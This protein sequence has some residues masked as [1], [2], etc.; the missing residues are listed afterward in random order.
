VRSRAAL[1]LLLRSSD[2][3]RST[4]GGQV[5]TSYRH[6]RETADARCAAGACGNACGAFQSSHTAPPDAR[7]MTRTLLLL[8]LLRQ[9]V[10]DVFAVW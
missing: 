7:C 4:R 3:S 5:G 10:D 6:R 2:D 8:L 1:L 9:R